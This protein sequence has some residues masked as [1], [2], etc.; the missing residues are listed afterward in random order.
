MPFGVL[1]D[2]G[3]VERGTQCGGMGVFAAQAAAHA[4]V[5]HRGHRI[6]LERIGI[7]FQCEC[8]ASRQANAGMVA[9][10]HV[11]V[12]A[13][14]HPLHP[15]TLGQQGR[16][17]GLDAAL[18]LELAFAFSHDHFQTLEFDGKSLGQRGL[19]L[20]HFIGTHRTQPLHAQ[21]FQ[22]G[23][24]RLVHVHHALPFVFGQALG[25][26]TGR[27]D[28]VL[29]AGGRG[30]AVFK[31]Q[32]HRIVTVEQR[33]LHASEQAVMPK[34]AIAHDR[35]HAPLHQRRDA[36]PTGQT[37]AVAQNR[38]PDRERFKGCQGMT[39]NVA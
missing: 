36:S 26:L 5:N 1:H 7:V 34:T 9:V 8:W 2:F 25:G 35:E 29:R 37:H 14:F 4:T 32:Q 33:T 39:T 6:H 21:A 30:V 23:F 20:F 18:A 12:Y 13:V 24:N 3:T 10:A 38:M 11:F 15:L 28:D 22:R 27:G 17:P 16:Q 19:H 31:N